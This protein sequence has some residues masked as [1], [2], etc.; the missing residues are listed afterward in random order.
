LAVYRVSPDG[1]ALR[2]PPVF[3]AKSTLLVNGGAPRA[4]GTTVA[5]EYLAQIWA[6]F[7][8]SDAVRRLIDPTL[9]RDLWYEVDSVTGI[10][11][12]T[13][14]PLLSV[15]AFS[16]RSAESVAQA[17]RVAGALEKYIASTQ[18]AL[19]KRQRSTLTTIARADKA[20]VFKGKRLTPG[21]MLFVLGI[22]ATVLVAFTRYNIRL[23][24]RAEL[25]DE[26]VQLTHERPTRLPQHEASPQEAEHE[27]V[28]GDAAA[29]SPPLEDVA[30]ARRRR[31]LGSR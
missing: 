23:G 9:K 20:E 25:Q 26:T 5:P 30:T 22:T 13:P 10:N 2:S 17:N 12:G 15:S 8:Q 7:A 11:S 21:L 31:T 1:V 4:D 24:R 16:T 6:Q 18:R 19:P 29:V 28:D 27:N 3:V 14:L